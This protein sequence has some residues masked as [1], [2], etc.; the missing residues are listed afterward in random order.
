VGNGEKV[1]SIYWD[2]FGFSAFA[3]YPGMLIF[4]IIHIYKSNRIAKNQRSLWVVLLIFGSLLVYPVYW[5]LYIWREPKKPNPINDSGAI[6]S[7]I[8]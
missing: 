6:K 2:L 7:V 4:Y 1:N 8:S 5:Y 3:S